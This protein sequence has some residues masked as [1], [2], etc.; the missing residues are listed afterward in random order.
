[1]NF[2]LCNAYGTLVYINLDRLRFQVIGPG[3]YA[4]DEKKNR[5]PDDAYIEIGKRSPIN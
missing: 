1:M 3:S 4:W 5:K 2:F